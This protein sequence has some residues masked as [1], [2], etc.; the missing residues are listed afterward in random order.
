M[1]IVVLGPP[2]AGK[3]TQAVKI[4]EHYKIPHISTGDLFRSNISE[5]TELGKLAKTYIDKGDLVPNEVTINMIS[6][7]LTHADAA[8]GF[9]LDGFP[10]AYDQAVA[11]QQLLAE[12]N[13]ETYAPD[14]H[15]QGLDAIL[16]FEISDEAVVERLK[17]RGREDDQESVILNRLK[18]YAEQTAPLLD[19]Y[20]K[21]LSV[22]D[23]LGSEEEVF[24]RTLAALSS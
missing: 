20:S 18:V 24:Q 6:E 11:L 16:S 9:I 3:G 12:K 23:A 17:S 1:K 5:G 10:R 13:G 22:I 2:G 4:A 8:N 15:G 7:R 19:F 14:N 21:E